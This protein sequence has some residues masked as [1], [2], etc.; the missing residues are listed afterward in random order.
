MHVS[1]P[2]SGTGVT[3]KRRIREV[4]DQKG[5]AVHCVEVDASV[6]D[7]VA[8]MNQHH[9]GSVLVCDRE[10]WVGIFT[11]RDVLTRIV[12]PRRDPDA[13]RVREVMTPELFTLSADHDLGDAMELMTT[14]RCRHVP[15][16]TKGQ[17]DGLLS[18]GDVT[19]AL[20]AQL[21]NE[22]HELESYIASPY[23]S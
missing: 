23:V 19:K 21:V 9:V 18:I 7:A 10:V 3:M 15:I 4:L 16:V 12:A 2:Q 8:L 13:T 1:S 6:M 14:R 11:E 17:L 5:N 20:R 22:L